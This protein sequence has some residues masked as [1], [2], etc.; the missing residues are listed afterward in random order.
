MRRKNETCFNCGHKESVHR[1]VE[2][3]CNFE[4]VIGNSTDGLDKIDCPCLCFDD[5]GDEE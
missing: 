2:G 5:G 1:I 4:I 3:R